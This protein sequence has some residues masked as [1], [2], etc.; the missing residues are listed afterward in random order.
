MLTVKGYARLLKMSHGVKWDL[1]L[2][3]LGLQPKGAKATLSISC[4]YGL[5]SNFH[6]F[7]FIFYK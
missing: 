4:P 2:G 5:R 6:A 1:L 3:K 7:D